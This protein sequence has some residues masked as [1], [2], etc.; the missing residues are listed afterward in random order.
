MESSGA[1]RR[2]R[3]RPF[4]R[5]TF[6]CTALGVVAVGGVTAGARST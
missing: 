5:R 6:L 3:A 2:R 1:R 4:T